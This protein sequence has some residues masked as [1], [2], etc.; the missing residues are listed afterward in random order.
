LSRYSGR[1]RVGTTVAVGTEWLSD[2]TLVCKVAG[3]TEGSLMVVMSVGERV[4]SSTEASSYDVGTG[5]SW[6]AGNVA[7]TGGA[8]VSVMGAGF[9]SVR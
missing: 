8:S 9:G 5:S 2:T 7:T 6:R 1:V 4:G 3:G